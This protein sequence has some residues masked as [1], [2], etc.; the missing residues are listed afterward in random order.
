LLLCRQPETGDYQV[1]LQ[2]GKSFF[3]HR[4]VASQPLFV[5]VDPAAIAKPTFAAF[6]ALL[7]RCWSDMV[8][9]TKR[10]QAR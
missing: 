5:H 7:V 3:D 1:N 6:I 2:A 8:L 9:Y 4:D 10:C